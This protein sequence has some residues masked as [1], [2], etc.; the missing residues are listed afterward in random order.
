MTLWG[1][2]LNFVG[3]LVVGI[4]GYRGLSSGWDGGIVWASP[5]WGFLWFLGWGLLAFGFAMQ[6]FAARGRVTT[7]TP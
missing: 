3:T 6:W 7:T 2:S 5:T 4:A 1:L